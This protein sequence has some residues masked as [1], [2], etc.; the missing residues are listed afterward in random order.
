MKLLVIALATTSVMAPNQSPATETEK[1]LQLR[2][3]SLMTT[4]AGMPHNYA[5]FV[6]PS[7][8]P[9]L[10]LAQPRHEARDVSRSSCKADQA[11]CY[12]AASGHIVYKP[13][14]QF[15]PDLPGLT[16]E[17]ISLKR[18]RIVFRYSF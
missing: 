3:K 12:D 4:T 8:E 15:M 17:N 2:P 13:A 14:R 5:P 10:G 11:L 9:K 6:T 7:A 1:A 16:P 18:N